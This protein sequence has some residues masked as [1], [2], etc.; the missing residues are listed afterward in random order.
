MSRRPPLFAGA[1]PNSQKAAGR[2]AC[3][4]FSAEGVRA[5]LQRAVHVAHVQEGLPANVLRARVVL[6]EVI[7][8]GSELQRRAA[9]P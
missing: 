2:R 5:N 8:G 4:L 7:E 1:Q 9:A 3:W 6:E